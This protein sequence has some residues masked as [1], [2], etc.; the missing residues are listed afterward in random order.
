VQL[1]TKMNCLDFEANRSKVTA[2]PVKKDTLGI[3][4]VVGSN[5]RVTDNLCG[6]G[7]LIHSLL[8]SWLPN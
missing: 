6:K 2:R 3:L 5:T 8:A 1:G 4:K 7:R